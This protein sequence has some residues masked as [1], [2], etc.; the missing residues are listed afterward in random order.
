MSSLTHS[1]K[2]VQDIR[3]RVGTD[4]FGHILPVS[5]KECSMWPLAAA[6]F[7]ISDIVKSGGLCTNSFWPRIL[8]CVQTNSFGHDVNPDTRRYL[9]FERIRHIYEDRLHDFRSKYFPCAYFFLTM[10]VECCVQPDSV[11]FVVNPG[12]FSDA[13]AWATLQ[14]VRA[15]FLLVLYCKHSCC[16]F[17]CSTAT[18]LW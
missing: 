11:V 6:V 12:S 17:R 18:L 15:V 16:L 1:S 10:R 3:A 9:L 5:T 2:R 13:Q 7:Q 14:A 8:C 4:L